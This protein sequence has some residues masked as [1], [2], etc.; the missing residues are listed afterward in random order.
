ML[1]FVLVPVFPCENSKLNLKYYLWYFYIRY[2]KISSENNVTVIMSLT[3]GGELNTDLCWREVLRPNLLCS[4]W[5]CVNWNISEQ[6]QLF[7]SWPF[8]QG[9]MLMTE[10]IAGYSL[11]NFFSAI[12]SHNV[13]TPKHWHTWFGMSL[14]VLRSFKDHYVLTA[15]KYDCEHLHAFFS[16]LG[17]PCFLRRCFKVEI[18]GVLKMM[19]CLFALLMQIYKF[20]VY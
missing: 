5:C 4:S 6:L 13:Q 20:S 8:Q 14:S 11:L 12:C 9:T 3:D 1:I 2:Y 10:C 17:Q 16:T 19:S 15:V 18:W 7:T